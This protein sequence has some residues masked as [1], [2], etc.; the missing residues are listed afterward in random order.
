MNPKQFSGKL[1]AWHSKHGRHDLPWQM[2]RNLYRVW[3]SEIMLQQTQVA[4]VIPYFKRFMDRFNTIESLAG[5][6]IDEVLHLW[7]GLGYY[8]RARN[9]HKAALSIVNEHQ[10]QF[11]QD[12]DTLLSLPGIGRSTAAA[13]LAQALNRRQPILDGNVKRVLCRWHAIDGWPGTTSVETQLWELSEQVTPHDHAADYTQAIMDLGAT[14]CTRT[15][16]RCG[17]CPVANGC[18]AHAT[19]TETRYPHKKP[20]KTL[21]TK[22]TMMLM[23]RHPNGDILLQRRPPSGIW[24]GLWSFPEHEHSDAACIRAWCREHTDCTITRIEAWP[25]VKHTFSHYRLNITP[26]HIQVKPRASAVM[27]SDDWVWYNTMHPDARGLATPVKALLE[28]L[29]NHP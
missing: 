29:R 5:A 13:I 6:S 4:T 16:P 12:I 3:I 18:M 9:L 25:A 10:G 11:P 15:H 19:A 28:K 2:D 21:P 17:I 8:A 24:G 1:L 27:D 26:L 20:K 22:Q 7:T 23:L 14:L